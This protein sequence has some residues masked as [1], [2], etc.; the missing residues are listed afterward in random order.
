M[1]E[2]NKW[3]AF[4]LS[5]AAPGA[6]QLYARSFWCV[7]WFCSVALFAIIAGVT[8]STNFGVVTLQAVLFAVLG[9]LSAE[10]A[11]RLCET[12]PSQL[13]RSGIVSRVELPPLRGRTVKAR[14]ELDVPYDR[15]KLWSTVANLSEFLTIDTFHEQVTMMRPEVRAGVDFVLSH[16]AFGVRF[17]RFG[18]ILRWEEGRGYSFSDLPNG[19]LGVGFPHVFFI[20]VEE[21]GD[22]MPPASR[23]TIEV[24]GKWTSRWIP[25]ALGRWWLYCVCREHARL[26]RKAL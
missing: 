12:T 9:L 11:K 1:S 3:S 6:G 7:P 8:S 10:H 16:N 25:A 21:I 15:K 14:I 24:R 5:L 19:K 23:L 2:P 20:R 17:R 26:L 4:L 18:R 13:R 22:R